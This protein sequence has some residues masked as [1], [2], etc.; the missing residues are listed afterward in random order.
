MSGPFNSD[1]GMV[2]G[3]GTLSTSGTTMISPNAENNYAGELALAQG[4]TWINTGVVNDDGVIDIDTAGSQPVHII[5]AAGDIFN[6]DTYG[7]TE[8]DAGLFLSFGGRASLTNAGTLT[9]GIFD[10]FNPVT[11]VVGCATTNTGSLI[12]Q[13][14]ATLVMEQRL[15][16]GGSITLDGGLVLEGGGALTGAFNGPG[17]L[18]LE[19]G[20]YTARTSFG[21]GGLIVGNVFEGEQ[22]PSP[23][24]AVDSAW[25]DAGNLV[26]EGQATLSL[27]R[28]AD[29]TVDG[30]LQLGGGTGN[31]TITGAGTL[32]TDGP[33]YF[34]LLFDNITTAAAIGGGATWVNNGTATISGNLYQIPDDHKGARIINSAGASM[35]LL[36][37]AILLG[38]DILTNDGTLSSSQAG[39]SNP[40]GNYYGCAIVNAAL[41]DVSGTN[42]GTETDGSLVIGGAFT[43]L[44]TGMVQIADGGALGLNGGGTLD[45]S[46]TGTAGGVY[47]ANGSFAIGAADFSVSIFS[48]QADTSLTSTIYLGDSSRGDGSFINTSDSTLAL[49]G[50]AAIVAQGH[51]S[52]MNDGMLVKSGHCM[53]AID[54]AMTNDGSIAVRAGNLLLG[55]LD[56]SGTVA[57]SAGTTLILAETPGGT[58][59]LQF[60]GSDAALVLDH[61]ASLA[62]LDG[63]GTG[64]RL[65]LGGVLA[66]NV[67]INGD[68]L[69]VT[70]ISGTFTFGSAFPG[71]RYGDIPRGWFGWHADHHRGR[72][73][74]R[75]A[76]SRTAGL[77]P[78][79]LIITK[80]APDSNPSRH[81]D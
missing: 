63:F 2:A 29:L 35:T 75:R 54:A 15:V 37:G 79:P 8:I 9:A 68:I 72:Q 73:R 7:Q 47:L 42:P 6:I 69:D 24:L 41:I 80:L 40:Y 50:N 28:G 16:N 27:G 18:A 76:A 3:A 49:A 55:A 4:L 52:F 45:G 1:T 33:T 62:T 23:I 59:S 60:L 30:T 66:T 20:K 32:T 70:T 14:G 65:E 31:G 57:I 12:V 25:V 46:V 78:R 51:V 56:G 48:N 53:G 67:V 26:L 44:A 13:Y 74:S 61:A 19:T 38:G 77:A 34:P 10:S 58:Q 22:L 64:D 39:L 71:R 36:G 11:D 81:T 17:D 21:E 5:N 43:S